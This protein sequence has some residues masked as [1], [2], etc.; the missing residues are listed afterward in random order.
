MPLWLYEN[1]ASRIAAT[2]KQS[3]QYKQKSSLQTQTKQGKGNHYFSSHTAITS[4]GQFSEKSKK[5]T[6]QDQ[7]RRPGDGRE[8]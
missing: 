2:K 6:K 7:G 3:S 1:P 5:I 8:L 4:L